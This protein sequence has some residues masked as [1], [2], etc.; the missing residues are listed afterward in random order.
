[1]GADEATQTAKLTSYLVQLATLRIGLCGLAEARFLG[2]G[3]HKVQRGWQMIWSGP[4]EDSKR[5]HGVALLLSTQ[6]ARCLIDYNAV[7]QRIMVARFRLDGGINM[8]AL[9]VYAPT[10]G[11]EE[12]VKDAFY[13]QLSSTL[14]ALPSRD[15]LVLM[16]DFNGQ[17]G[18]DSSAFGGTVGPHVL[19]QLLTATNNGERLLQLA[20]A[21]EIRLANTF[22]KHR[23]LHTATHVLPVT[24]RR[25]LKS[26]LRVIDYFGV[27]KRFMSSVTDCRV[28]RGFDA[29]SDH[30]LLV[31][32]LRLRLSAARQQNSSSAGKTAVRFHVSKLQQCPDT[33]VAFEFEVQNR[34]NLLKGAPE[35]PGPEAEWALLK[36]AAQAAA[37]SALGS[38]PRLK[39]CSV[40][41]SALSMQKISCKHKAHAAYLSNPSSANKAEYRRCNNAAKAAVK[42]DQERFYRQQAKFAEDA[43]KCGNLA[44]FHK[45]IQ[46]VFGHRVC[47]GSSNAEPQTLLGGADGKTVLKGREA[48]LGKFAEH[49]AQ[50]LNCPASLD[51][52]MQQTLE[53]LVQQVE[54]GVGAYAQAAPAA[55]PPSLK[56]VAQAVFALR[57]GAAPGEDGIAAPM[58]KLSA[59]LLKWLHRVIAAVW[60][61]GRAPVDWKRA[62]LVALYKGKGDK[63]LSDNYRGISLLSIPGKVYALVIL[64]RVSDHI[65]SQLL[66]SQ[67]AF[68]KGRGLTDSLFTIR[69]LISK[70]VEFGQ[71]LHMAFVDLRKAYDCVPR[72][73]LWRILRAYGV[74]PKL[75]ELL[76]DLHT[77]TQAAVR[78]GSSLSEWFEVRSGVRQGCVIAPLLFNIYMDYVVKLALSLMPPDCGVKLAY[79]ADGQLHR[80]EGFGEGRLELVR[81]LLYA[82]DMVLLSHNPDELRV[83][84]Q[85]MDKVAAGM[86]MHIN[87]SKTEI[88]GLAKRKGGVGG[89][90]QGAVPEVVIAEGVVKQVSKFKYLGCMIEEHGKLDTELAARK[91]KAVGRFRQLVKLWGT[92]YLSLATKIRMY[93]AYVLPILLF[94]SE[95]WALRLEQSQMLER[96]HSSCL[97]SCLGVKLSDR[98]SNAYVRQQCRIVDLADITA[99]YRLRWLG[100]VGRMESGRLPHI[101]LFS[102]LYGVG[103]RPRGRPPTRWEDCVRSDLVERLGIQEGD[104]L[105]HCSIRSAWRGRLW[106]LSHTA[107][108]ACPHWRRRARRA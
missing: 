24:T 42:G 102:S 92:K 93:R 45:H 82:D 19:G 80:R 76:E 25:P 83:M 23:L 57:N 22:F 71:P 49:F 60:E 41:L 108:E 43:F 79:H 17:L 72:A 21:H 44:V 87:A 75:I 84:L 74:H 14:D 107:D 3:I 15:L 18:T 97:R 70:C 54:Q 31:L 26:C 99:A 35:Q 65:D 51:P 9:V 8:S 40:D 88:L 58:L 36:E 1:M 10:E 33:Q 46:R 66:D 104:W 96:V 68:R 61:S 101:A 98:H 73:T 94:G 77:G 59:T 12:A 64:S 78:M 47:G 91:G 5:E 86:G 39:A 13:L 63:K 32:T 89:E 37:S 29:D 6:W 4:P 2:N 27:S 20:T 11:A 85:I 106:G 48:V 7:N 81:A 50:V 69:M 34:F 55:E 105:D 62:L 38:Q 30:R 103:K 53:D 28:F 90:Q 67:S 95:T 16:G 52:Q 56:E 100:H